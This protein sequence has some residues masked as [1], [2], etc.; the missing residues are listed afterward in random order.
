MA[1]AAFSTPD[2]KVVANR[3]PVSISQDSAAQAKTSA[4]S[5]NVDRSLSSFNRG[6]RQCLGKEQVVFL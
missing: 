3:N 4:E 1:N 5:E 6:S 2:L